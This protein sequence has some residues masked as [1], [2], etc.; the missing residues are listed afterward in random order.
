M[1]NP[2]A[3]LQKKKEGGGPRAPS[4]TRAHAILAGITTL[5]AVAAAAAIWD[6]LLIYRTA[7][8]EAP[9]PAAPAG[10]LFSERELD[11]TLTLIREREQRFEALAAG[12]PE[13]APAAPAPTPA[14]K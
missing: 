10:Q 1:K 2:F 8:R 11:E 7:T 14:K 5:L 6:G 3:F 12:V 4:F 9:A 13:P